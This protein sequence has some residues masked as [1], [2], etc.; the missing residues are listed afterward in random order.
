MPSITVIATPG[1][2]PCAMDSDTSGLAAHGITAVLAAA[3][4]PGLNA[5]GVIPAFVD[6][7]V[8]AETTVRFRVRRWPVS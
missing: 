8:F 6:Q 1:R 7:S 3:D 5:F 2:L 4:V